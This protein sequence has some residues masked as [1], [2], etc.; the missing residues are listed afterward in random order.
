MTN[1]PLLVRYY[2][3]S[4]GLT[5]AVFH[6]LLGHAVALLMKSYYGDDSP[7]RF[8]DPPSASIRAFVDTAPFFFK[9]GIWF[10][11][12]NHHYQTPI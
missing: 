5:P 10:C 4:V 2:H 7:N 3:F 12:R 1:I 8:S 9:I 6:V 11:I